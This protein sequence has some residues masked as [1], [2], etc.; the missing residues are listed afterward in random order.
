MTVKDIV[1]QICD[2]GNFVHGSKEAKVVHE[3]FTSVYGSEYGQVTNN[4]LLKYNRQIENRLYQHNDHMAGSRAVKHVR[5]VI[6][7]L[8]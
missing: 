3:V 2:V 6:R 5:E 8:K 7:K 1:K 4:S